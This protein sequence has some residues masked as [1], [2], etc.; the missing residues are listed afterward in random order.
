MDYGMKTAGPSAS[1]AGLLFRRD[2][3]RAEYQIPLLM[4]PVP[5][6]VRGLS[7]ELVFESRVAGLKATMP[8][9]ITLVTGL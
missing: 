1:R 2:P 5:A 3:G 4:D 8:R 9:S 6:Q 7:T